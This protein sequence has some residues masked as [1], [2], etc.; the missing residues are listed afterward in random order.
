VARGRPPKPIERIKVNAR[1][2]THKANGSELVPAKYQMQPRGVQIPVAPDDLH[3]RGMTEWEKIWSAGY[4]LSVEQDYHWVAM[5]TTSYD[6]IDVYRRV[7]LEEGITVQGIH[8]VLIAHPLIAEIRKAQATIMK[9]LSL[10]G[11]S[12]T[13]RARLS[14]GEVKQASA[15]ADL[16]AKMRQK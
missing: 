14:L 15:L 1:N 6:E 7:I 16:N 3:D 8:G 12:P 11:F 2:E 10:L 4:W 13:D 5:I 9:C